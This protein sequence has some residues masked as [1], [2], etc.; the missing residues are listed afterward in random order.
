MKNTWLAESWPKKTKG[1]G[2][3]VGGGGGGGNVPDSLQG[4]SSPWV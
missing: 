4:D 2:R 1:L 3:G